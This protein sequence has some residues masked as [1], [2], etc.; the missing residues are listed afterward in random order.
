MIKDLYQQIQK[1]Q[2][3][4]EDIVMQHRMPSSG[5][6]AVLRGIDTQR[7]VDVADVAVSA[8]G[9]GGRGRWNGTQH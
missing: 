2:R 5:L 9:D 6:F 1:G 7:A 4:A 8:R 3:S